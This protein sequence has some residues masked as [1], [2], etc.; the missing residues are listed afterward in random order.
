MAVTYDKISYPK[1]EESIKFLLDDSFP[2]VYI[3]PVFRM[4]GNECIRVNLES[5]TSEELATNFE[6]R[7]YNVILRYYTKADMSKERDNEFVKNRI[8]K[9]KKLLI[10]NQVNNTNSKWAK[11]EV[12]SITYNVENDENED[13]DDLFVAELDLNITNFNHFT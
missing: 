6:V 3:S 10:D 1:I 13:K 12:E 8:D 9:L 2:N 5:S 11:L 7:N 4:V